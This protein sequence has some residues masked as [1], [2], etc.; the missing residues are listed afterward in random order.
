MPMIFHLEMNHNISVKVILLRVENPNIINMKKLALIALITF[1]AGTMFGQFTI[2]P[3][4]GYTASN[5][6]VDKSEIENN[7]RNN[8][9]IGVF[10]RFGKKIYVQP[11]VNWLTQGSILKYPS[12]SNPNPIEQDIKISTIQV[13]LSVGWRIINREESYT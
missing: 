13:P 6:T 9:L 11:E 10:M 7:L 2:G 8:F 4:I 3:Q 1:A 12:L 5:L